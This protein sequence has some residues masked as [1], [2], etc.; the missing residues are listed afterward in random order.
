MQ[1]PLL[2]ILY[3]TYT[4][5]DYMGD[6]LLIGLQQIANVHD[7]PNNQFIYKQSNEVFN[8]NKHTLYGYGFTLYNIVD[9][10]L[11]ANITFKNINISDYDL[12]IF[13]GIQHQYGLLLQMLPLIK[14][15]KL[16]VVDGEDNQ[17]IIPFGGKFWSRPALWFYPA[18]HRR[19]LYFKRE[20]TPK[21]VQY[22]FYKLMPVK[23]LK[24]YHP[25]NLRQISFSIPAEKI[26][27]TIPEKIKKF[28]LHIV[29][30]EVAENTPGSFTRYAFDS[31]EEYYKDLQSSKFGITTKKG[32]WDCLRHYEIAANGAVI[33]FRDLDKKPI[34]CAP[35]GLM[36]EYNCLSYN[37]YKDLINKI[38]QLTDEKYN[39]MLQQS[40][41][42]VRMN[43]CINVAK[44]FLSECGI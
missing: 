41:K 15:T 43:D 13:S 42:W 2:N 40:L 34:T 26:V 21:S 1:K 16:V 38:E 20:L 11:R 29:D 35:H 18:L 8:K 3:F 33:C 19:F 7:V 17:K 28:P 24:N 25:K 6:S 32:G 12:V 31:E 30:L 22:L 39:D 23:W 37:S 9:N 27:T 10:K 4:Q 36:H 14:N 44:R 5:Q